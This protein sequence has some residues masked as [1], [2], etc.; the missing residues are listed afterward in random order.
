MAWLRASRNVPPPPPP[1]APERPSVF[2]ATVDT[3]PQRYEI[4]GLVHASERIAAG[5]FPTNPLLDALAREAA[6]MGAD[7]VIGIRVSQ[8]SVP[9]MSRERLLGRVSDHYGGFVTATALGT[10]VRLLSSAGPG[11]P[12]T[13]ARAHAR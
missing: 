10:A 12:T 8:V 2:M 13:Y 9:G 5:C 4:L 6:A 11:R 1:P 7:G 3:L